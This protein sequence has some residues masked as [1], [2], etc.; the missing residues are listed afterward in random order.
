VGMSPAKTLRRS[1]GAGPRSADDRAPERVRAG[2]WRTWKAPKA[3]LHDRPAKKKVVSAEADK[4]RF[5]RCCCSSGRST[6]QF[7]IASMTQAGTLNAIHER[8]EKTIRQ[9]R[10]PEITARHSATPSGSA[11]FASYFA[12]RLRRPDIPPSFY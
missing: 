4:N 5:S 1:R 9:S 6:Q 11:I 10:H 2:K 7:Q 8:Y 3:H 12:S